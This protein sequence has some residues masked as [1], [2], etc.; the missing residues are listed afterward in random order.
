MNVFSSNLLSFIFRALL[1]KI[2]RI[3]LC[4]N[5][6]ESIIVDYFPLAN[7]RIQD[8]VMSNDDR[9]IARQRRSNMQCQEVRDRC[10]SYMP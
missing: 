5:E 10:K 6:C 3:I 7:K 8:I 2:Y 1:L 9:Y 4:Y